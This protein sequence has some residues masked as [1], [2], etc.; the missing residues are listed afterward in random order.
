MPTGP[1]GVGDGLV[2]HQSPAASAA[3]LLLRFHA[4]PWL[5]QREEAVIDDAT[6]AK[7]FAV[8]MG[9]WALGYGMGLSVSWVYKIRDVA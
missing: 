5:Q 9:C 7:I 2:Q 1:T 6:I 8:L 3:H 4:G